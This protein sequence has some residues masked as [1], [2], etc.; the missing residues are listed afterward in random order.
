MDNAIER[1]Q[2][3][4]DDTVLL[5]RTLWPD[6]ETNVQH[7][8]AVSVWRGNVWRNFCPF[9]STAD[10]NYVVKWFAAQRAPHK[11]WM[12]AYRFESE[13]APSLA[14]TSAF[15]AGILATPEQIAMAA[16]QAIQE[17]EK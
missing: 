17:K 10:S 3:R 11:D 9:D 2:K 12:T 8:V 14:T 7:G 16:I 5:A 6:A 15:W 13:L 1:N 4:V